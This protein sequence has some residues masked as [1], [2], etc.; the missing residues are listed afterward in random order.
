[1]CTDYRK[2]NYCTK[3]DTF[4]KPRIDDSR[5]KI[6]QSKFVSKFD[7]LKGFWQIPLSEKAKEISALVT[8]DG[9]FQ[10]KVKN[11]PATFQR[12]VNKVSSGLDGVAAYIDDVIIY[13]DTWEEH[14]RIIRTFFDRLSEFQL[15]VNLNKSEFCHGTLTFLCH[16]VGQ[17]QVKPIFAKV[18]AI[19]DF[20]EPSSKKQLLR[21]LGMAGYY[22]N[23]CNNF[24]SVSVPLTDLLTKNCKFVWNENCQNC[25]ENF[26]PMLINAPVL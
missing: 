1:M 10:Y 16:V 3:T 9:L 8:P 12:L 26:K 13:R 2:V 25:Y 22:R 18:Q 20:P 6:G 15:T 5:D 19:N 24:S 21:F 4:P 23:F 11:S 17:G 14:L 7:L